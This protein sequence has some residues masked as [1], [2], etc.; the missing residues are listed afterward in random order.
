VRAARAVV[1]RAEAEAK[2]VRPGDWVQIRVTFANQGKTPA[3]L[4]F[5]DQLP[6]VRGGSS[7]KLS[8]PG[9]D[10]MAHDLKGRS[11]DYPANVGLL[12]MLTPPGAADRA[13]VE[14]AP[15]ARAE[16]TVWWRANGFNP[17]KRYA[18]MAPY[19]VLTPEPLP[20][21]K[22]RLTIGLPLVGAGKNP[23]VIVTIQP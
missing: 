23:S 3:R 10:V 17:D 9:F 19:G 15:G 14:I 4:A 13:E 5:H 18:G 2:T 6:R 1:T 8:T 22:Y 21:A 16:A 11:V 20:P 7:G 12:G